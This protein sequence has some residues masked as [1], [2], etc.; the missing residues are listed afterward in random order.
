MKKRLS[1]YEKTKTSFTASQQPAVRL[2]LLP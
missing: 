2:L 1:E